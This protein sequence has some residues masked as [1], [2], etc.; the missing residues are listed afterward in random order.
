MPVN[1]IKYEMPSQGGSEMDFAFEIRECKASSDYDILH[2]LL[3]A[4]DITPEQC[5]HLAK[6]PFQFEQSYVHC[7][8]HVNKNSQAQRD[9]IKAG[10]FIVKYRMESRELN[11][12]GL[13]SDPTTQETKGGR[14]SVKVVYVR[15]ANQDGENQYQIKQHFTVD[16]LEEGWHTLPLFRSGTGRSGTGAGAHLHLPCREETGLLELCTHCGVGDNSVL[17]TE[18]RGCRRKDGLH[19]PSSEVASLRLEQHQVLGFRQERDA[20]AVFANN[21]VRSQVFV[22][23]IDRGTESLQTVKLSDSVSS[24]QLLCTLS[25]G[26]TI[27]EKQSIEH[28]VFPQSKIRRQRL[29]AKEE[30]PAVDI[31]AHN[32]QHLF[33]SANSVDKAALSCL[34]KW[35]VGI[36]EDELKRELCSNET[37]E[38]ARL[39]LLDKIVATI[40]ST[41]GGCTFLHRDWQ[42]TLNHAFMKQGVVTESGID[43]KKLRQ[44]FPRRGATVEVRSHT[45]PKFNG[46]YQEMP[47]PVNK[48]PCF[49]NESKCYIYRYKSYWLMTSKKPTSPEPFGWHDDG[50]FFFWKQVRSTSTCTGLPFTFMRC[51]KTMPSGCHLQV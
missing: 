37:A 49:V 17:A 10:D 28:I 44:L 30:D 8:T 9:G 19:L 27:L 31:L 29:G 7:V 23:E 36:F 15:K 40:N 32:W 41:P 18:C 3:L 26:P 35:S 48:C 13:S 25:P 43:V 16:C 46:V 42:K 38:L 20:R 1:I 50:G 11:A 2:K 45:R 39:T 5:G 51:R 4:G 14:T 24:C 47:S 21:N 33:W 22:A 6:K 12:K 34:L